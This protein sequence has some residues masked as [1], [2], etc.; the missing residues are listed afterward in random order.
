[1]G[2][3]VR[4]TMTTPE[5]PKETPEERRARKAKLREENA[6]R[7]E[8]ELERDYLTPLPDDM[9]FNDLQ[10]EHGRLRMKIM[11]FQQ[12]VITGQLDMG[13]AQEFERR[14]VEKIHQVEERARTAGSGGYV[15]RKGE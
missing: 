3:W 8:A 12:L 1:M 9:A 15:P 10:M 14:M 5:T 4:P 2:R 7:L 11:E 13:K 6:A